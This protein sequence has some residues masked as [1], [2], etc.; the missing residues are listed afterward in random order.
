V[1]AID[2]KFSSWSGTGGDI[3]RF[4]GNADSCETFSQGAQGIISAMRALGDGSQ[5]R[6]IKPAVNDFAFVVPKKFWSTLF[7]D[8][9]NL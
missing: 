1:K 7:V 4:Q 3:H 5:R 6:F 9:L 2:S 8:E